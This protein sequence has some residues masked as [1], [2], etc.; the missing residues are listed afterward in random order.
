VDARSKASV[1]LPAMD[2]VRTD[3]HTADK[4]NVSQ[5]MLTVTPEITGVTPAMSGLLGGHRITITGSGLAPGDLATNTGTGGCGSSLSEGVVVLAAVA[6]VSCKPVECTSDSLVCEVLP[7]LPQA[8][9][10]CTSF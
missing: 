5:Y 4:K 8:Q 7:S 2:F 1:S 3:A 10:S 9:G 6:G